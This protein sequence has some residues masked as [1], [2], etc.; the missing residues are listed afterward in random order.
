[1][2]LS[3]RLHLKLAGVRPAWHAD[4]ITVGSYQHSRR[5]QLADAMTR[6]TWQADQG[7]TRRAHNAD[8][9]RMAAFASLLRADM[10]PAAAI[11]Y[12]DGSAV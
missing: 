9:A 3:Y 10:T 11:E 8:C 5:V 4:A 6:A 1:M 7:A 12:L 2:K